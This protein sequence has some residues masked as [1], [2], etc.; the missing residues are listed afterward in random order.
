MHLNLHGNKL[1]EID[2][3]IGDMESL[4]EL[5]L[6][7]N[8]LI[9][10]PL[11]LAECGE[12]EVLTLSHNQLTS[13]PPLDALTKVRFPRYRYLALSDSHPARRVDPGTQPSQRASPE[14]QQ[15]N[16]LVFISA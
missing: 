13:L 7:H 12:L 6:A 11:A 16:V 1:T 14:E 15:R 3:A 9:S 8:A 10:L 4:E 5:Y 2:E